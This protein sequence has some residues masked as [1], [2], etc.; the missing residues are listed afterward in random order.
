[1]LIDRSTVPPRPD[2]QQQALKGSAHSPLRSPRRGQGR[3]PAL[4]FRHRPTESLHVVALAVARWSRATAEVFSASVLSS[5]SDGAA[6]PA[7]SPVLC[8][9]RGPSRFGGSRSEHFA[10]FPSEWPQVPH[11]LPP[12]GGRSWAYVDQDPRSGAGPAASTRI[13]IV[14]AETKAARA[15]RRLRPISR[16]GRSS[17]NN[18]GKT[19]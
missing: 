4:L 10:N 15:P 2:P 13:Q 17:T 16:L 3:V 19:T 6:A 5:R 18:E 12:V 1:M 14:F 11:R 7:R 8:R 9:R